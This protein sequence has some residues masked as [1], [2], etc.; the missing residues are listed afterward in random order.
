MEGDSCSTGSL[1][2]SA[3]RVLLR[4]KFREVK[5]TRDIVSVTTLTVMTEVAV[6]E[7]DTEQPV[8]KADDLQDTSYYSKQTVKDAF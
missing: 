1:A 3:N 7:R 2:L 4:P 6:K 5:R 8:K